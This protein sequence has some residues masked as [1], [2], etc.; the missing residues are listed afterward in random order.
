MPSVDNPFLV[1]DKP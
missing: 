1:T